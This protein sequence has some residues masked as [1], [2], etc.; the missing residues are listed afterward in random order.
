MENQNSY[1]PLESQAMI[2]EKPHKKHMMRIVFITVLILALAGGGFLVLSQDR[3]TAQLKNT[4]SPAPAQNVE[5]AST[6]ATE[7]E[8]LASEIQ[9]RTLPWIELKAEGAETA[10]VGQEIMISVQGFTGQ[11]D[12]TGYDV[13]FGIDPAQFEVVSIT[14]ELPDFKV[15]SFNRD[16]YHSVTGIKD[17]Q[18][19]DKTLLSGN[20]ILK[21]IIKP[22]KAGQGVVSIM[23]TKGMEKTQFVD[24]E[25]EVMEPQ[26][27]S[28]IIQAN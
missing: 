1:G 24:S 5:Q 25:V 16:T 10:R 26:V 4:V 12:V 9:D 13:L 21:L 7:Y 17:L 2:E 20:S 8:M 11:R 15:Q 18:S 28:V 6:Q 27:G 23:S 3:F 14:S 19:K 22:L